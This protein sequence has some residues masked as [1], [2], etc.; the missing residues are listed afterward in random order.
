MKVVHITR[1]SQ[2]MKPLLLIKKD[3]TELLTNSSLMIIKGE[4]GSGKSRI[5]MNFMVGFSG[6][7]EDLEFEYEPCP[8]GKHV[9]YIST[10]MSRYHLQKRLLKILEFTPK[11]YEDQLVV[12]DAMQLDDKLAELEDICKKYPP[13]VI[14]IDQLGDLVIDINNLQQATDIIKKLSNGLEKYDCGIIGIVHQNEDAGINAKA[15]GHLGS[16]FEQKVVSSLAI[17]DH[18]KGYRIKTTKVREGKP[19]QIDAVF[20][21]KTSMLKRIV[22]PKDNDLVTQLKLPCNRTDLYNQLKV[23]T[24][25]TSPTTL[26]DITNKLLS[27]GYIKEEFKGKSSFISLM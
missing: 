14:I 8:V 12:L 3:H 18:S 13:H 7:Q 17:S 9:I 24:A 6:V 26:K 2:Y 5:A 19:I 20:N 25:K 27:E 21:E 10:E 23:L 4:V 11:E 22:I 15:R 1:K 16:L